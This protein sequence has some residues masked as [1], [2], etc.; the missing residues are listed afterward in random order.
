LK[1]LGSA[2]INSNKMDILPPLYSPGT[3]NKKDTTLLPPS[4]PISDR[5]ENLQIRIFGK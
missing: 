2:K 4:R 5:S 1:A 3:P